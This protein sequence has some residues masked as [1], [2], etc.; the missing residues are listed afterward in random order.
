MEEKLNMRQKRK[1]KV[2]DGGSNKVNYYNL[3]TGENYGDTMPLAIPTV[4]KAFF[5]SPTTNKT[6]FTENITDQNNLQQ[7]NDYLKNNPSYIGIFD[8]GRYY[9]TTSNSTVYDY[10]YPFDSLDGMYIIG[11]TK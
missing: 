1:N 2:D 11:V 5:Y 9:H 8:N 6:I 3:I 10:K 7:I 4:A